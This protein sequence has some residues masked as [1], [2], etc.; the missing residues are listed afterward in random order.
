M[1]P[2]NGDRGEDHGKEEK[3]RNGSHHLGHE[4]MIKTQYS[5]AQKSIVLGWMFETATHATSGHVFRQAE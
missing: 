1:P 5:A 2:G 4:V 3:V